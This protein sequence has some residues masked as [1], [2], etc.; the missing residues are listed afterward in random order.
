MRH[1]RNPS[2]GTPAGS[3]S[4]ILP[5]ILG[6]FALIVA[7]LALLSFARAAVPVD[8]RVAS[9]AR[10]VNSFPLRVRWPKPSTKN[11]VLA[12]LQ[13]GRVMLLDVD[14]LYRQL[15]KAPYPRR[16][17]PIDVNQPGLSVRFYPLTNEAYCLRF[18]IQEDAGETLEV[19]TRQ[20]SA[21]QRAR[22]RF[23]K[24]RFSLFFWVTPDSFESFRVL[25]DSLQRDG[26]DVDWK[27]VEA[28]G[29]V[30]VCQG[31]E[32]FRGMEPQ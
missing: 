30:E 17:R 13:A 29:P 20:G 16:P 10:E 14:P 4:D 24:D 7:C 25:R 12:S 3:L 27:P 22:L 11:S 26:V 15:L 5:S 28:D 32:G 8:A 9:P 21:W 23:P 18:R 19:A 6:V 2:V 31:V 1:R